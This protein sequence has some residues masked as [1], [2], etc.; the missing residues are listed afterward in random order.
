MKLAFLIPTRNRA[1]LVINAIESLLDRQDCDT[2]VFVSDNSSADD[3]MRILSTYCRTR[4]HPRLTYLRPPE[5]LTMGTHWDW[6]VREVLARSTATHVTVHYDR[7]YSKP[8]AFRHVMEVAAR[9]P[10]LLITYPI[11]QIVAYDQPQTPRLWQVRWSGHTYRIRTAR[12]LAMTAAGRVSDMGQAWPVLSNC[13]VPREAIEAIIARY[14]NVCDS[15]G[16]DTRFGFRFC[17][18]FDAFL[19]FDRTLAVIYA[20]HR[21]AGAGYLSGMG[22]DFGDFRASWGDQ[23]WLEAAPI[24]GVNLGHNMLYHEYELV[25]REGSNLPPVDRNGYLQEISLGLQFIRDAD[26]RARLQ[27]LL[28]EHGWR[29]VASFAPPP[30]RLPFLHRLRRRLALLRRNPALVLFL[31]DRFG[32]APGPISGFPF[33]DDAEAIRY[34]IKYP[35]QVE[36]NPDLEV[37]EPERV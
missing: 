3:Q 24:P 12:V 35:F 9:H 14:G 34:A 22:G 23:P 28:E 8:G 30:E 7:K 15:V 10:G 17:S 36:T 33:R 16:P 2:E 19:H 6:G 4:A 11:D 32:V 1:E 21:S 5:L 20:S 37:M 29:E 27:A 31:A 13:I 26:A 25:R 18:L